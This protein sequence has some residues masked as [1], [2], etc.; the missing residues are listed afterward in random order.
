MYPLT[1][2]F[3]EV[4]MSV[5]VPPRMEAKAS[6]I[7]NRDGLVFAFLAIPTPVA[8]ASPPPWWCS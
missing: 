4:P 5:Q 8:R 2:T 1:A 3:V 6:G 7:S